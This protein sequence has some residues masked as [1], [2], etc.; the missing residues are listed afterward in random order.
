MS[1]TLVTEDG[2]GSPESR[3]ETDVQAA[4]QSHKSD[5]LLV[6]IL[7]IDVGIGGIEY[8]HGA[9]ATR[10]VLQEVGFRIDRAVRRT[11]ARSHVRFGQFVVVLPGLGTQGDLQMVAEGLYRMLSEA[12]VADGQPVDIS[13]HMGAAF[14]SS[15]LRQPKKLLRSA[16]LAA[17]EAQRRH[18]PLHVSGTLFGSIARR[19]TLAESRSRRGDRAEWTGRRSERNYRASS[20]EASPFSTPALTLVSSD[21]WVAGQA[22]G[23]EEAGAADS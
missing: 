19:L 21:D 15:A 12:Y 8:L 11:D 17:H 6:G 13:I 10:S 9:A 20:A 2:V 1:T 22:D 7:H 23:R 18:I 14:T 3:L 5:R 16:A 4:M